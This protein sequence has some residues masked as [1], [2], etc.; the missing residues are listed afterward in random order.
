MYIICNLSIDLD[1]SPVKYHDAYMME[2]AE[3]LFPSV[4]VSIQISAPLPKPRRRVSPQT[5]VADISCYPYFLFPSYK[6]S[7]S[8]S[9]GSGY[10]PIVLFPFSHDP[11]PLILDLATAKLAT[12]APFP[13]IDFSYF[14]LW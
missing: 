3:F 1:S 2:S 13:R 9:F 14:N 12:I 11:M 5:A 10:L 8:I 4:W 7:Y 6:T